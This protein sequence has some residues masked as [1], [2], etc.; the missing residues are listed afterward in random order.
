MNDNLY[1]AAKNLITKLDAWLDAD[2][3]FPDPEY[4]EFCDAAKELRAAVEARTVGA[5]VYENDGR[6]ADGD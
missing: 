3:I 2:G 1:N 4:D 6:R 5:G